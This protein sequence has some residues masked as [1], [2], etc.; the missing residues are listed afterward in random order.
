MV[1]ADA[2][3]AEHQPSKPSTSK[4]SPYPPAQRVTLISSGRHVFATL[5]TIKEGHDPLIMIQKPQQSLKTG[6]CKVQV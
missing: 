5:H 2:A 6:L 1:A 4:Q 3:M